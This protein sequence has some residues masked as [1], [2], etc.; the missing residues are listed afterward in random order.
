MLGKRIHYSVTFGLGVEELGGCVGVI[1]IEK[2][3]GG[4]GLHEE[5]GLIYLTLTTFCWLTKLP[6]EVDMRGAGP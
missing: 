3:E 4:R 5:A 2:G 1:K 6:G